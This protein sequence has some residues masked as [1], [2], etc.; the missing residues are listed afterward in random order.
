MNKKIS[1]S[2]AEWEVMEVL[3]TE[4][5]ISSRHIIE[6]LGNH[7]WKPTTIRTLLSRLVKKNFAGFIEGDY[8]YTYHPLIERSELVG[9]EA[10]NML[11]KLYNGNLSSMVAGFIKKNKLSDKDKDELRELLDM[12]KGRNEDK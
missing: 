6:K 4:A 12:G 11:K 7:G 2:E 5:P 8:A 10:E 9:T 1:I 3:W